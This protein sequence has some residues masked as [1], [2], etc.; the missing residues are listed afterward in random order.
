[1]TATEQSRIGATAAR[2]RPPGALVERTP[3]EVAALDR[4]VA[5]LHREIATL[6]RE[7]DKL[8]AQLR[9]L[10]DKSTSTD[11]RVPPIPGGP[12]RCLRCGY[13][14]NHAAIQHNLALVFASCC[15][16]CDGP[17]AGETGTDPTSSTRPDPSTHLG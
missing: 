15:P 10:S 17:L 5:A 6:R 4:E 2:A 8:R 11:R 7:N 1:M 16:R 3:R 12:R 13:T 9:T 14:L